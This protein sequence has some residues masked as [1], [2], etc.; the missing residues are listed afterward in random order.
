MLIYDEPKS[1]EVQDHEIS[2]YFLVYFRV[3]SA[4]NRII[5]VAI[6]NRNNRES[7]GAGHLA[8]K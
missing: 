3:K 6:D 8:I 1:R 2:H 5:V 4:L 7:I